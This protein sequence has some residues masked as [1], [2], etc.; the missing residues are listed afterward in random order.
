MVKTKLEMDFKDEMEKLF[1]LSLD[2]PKSDLSPQTVKAAMEAVVA[3]D[4]FASKN[5][6]LT[7]AVVARVVTTSVDTLEF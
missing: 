7:E 6:A 2:A 5:G 1:R 4:I 3:Q